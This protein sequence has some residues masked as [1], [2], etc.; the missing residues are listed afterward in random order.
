MKVFLAGPIDYWWNENWETPEHIAYMEWRDH[1]RVR[2]VEAGHCVYLPHQAIKGAW[3]ESMQAINDLAIEICD[4]FV[5]LTPPGVPAYGTEAET[6]HA[7][8]LGKRVGHAPP[9]S[10]W[11]IDDLL[12]RL[13]DPYGKVHR[14]SYAKRA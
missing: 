3:D 10:H 11:Q 13:D 8:A 4:A 2:L 5:Y 7:R 12:F 6:K 1:I 14:K 9:G